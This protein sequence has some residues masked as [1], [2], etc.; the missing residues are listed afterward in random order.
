[1][2]LDNIVR[3]IKYRKWGFKIILGDKNIR[4]NWCE[5]REGKPQN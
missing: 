3:D 1:M 4:M 2:F 5:E